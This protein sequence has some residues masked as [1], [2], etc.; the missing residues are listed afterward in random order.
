MFDP[1]SSF[2]DSFKTKGCPNPFSLET[3]ALTSVDVTTARNRLTSVFRMRSSKA[4]ATRDSMLN[5]DSRTRTNR[6]LESQDRADGHIYS[7]RHFGRFIAQMSFSTKLDEQRNS[8]EAAN[9]GY[10]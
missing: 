10:A 8:S 6:A 9:S 4:F 5:L 3:P 7:G 1:A 2:N